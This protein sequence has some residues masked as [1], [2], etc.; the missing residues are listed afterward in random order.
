[1][2]LG[3]L[4]KKIEQVLKSNS[5]FNKLYTL[6]GSLVVKCIG[7][8][9]RLKPKTILFISYSGK[10]FN[11]SPKDIY[12]AMVNDPF[13]ADYTFIWAFKDVDK[14]E[15]GAH[16][17]KVKVDTLSYLLIAL[18][19]Q[20][21]VT[22]VNIER[23]L[24]FKKHYTKYINTWHGIP[25]KYVGNHVQ[26]RSDFNFYT[27]DVFTYSGDYEY[28]IYKEAFKLEDRNLYKYGMP[29]N[30][31]LIKNDRT[32][33]QE[34]LDAL[35]IVNKKVI[36]YA[37][38]WRDDERDLVLMDLK[39]F[40]DVLSS[41]YV[42]LIKMHGLSER[43]NISV[44]DFVMDVS[45][46]EDTSKLLLAVDVLIT[47][48]SSI[49]FDFGLLKRPIL[50]YM[51]DYDKYKKERGLYFDVEDTQLSYSTS[52]DALLAAIE[53]LNYEA[54][55]KIVAKFTQRFIEVQEVGATA[56]I[57]NTVFKET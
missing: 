50:L 17:I 6:L 5:L 38:T 56:S 19:A 55:E 25:M 27:V 30:E 11:D 26:G 32:L 47:D 1:M 4:M 8:F 45:D 29:R 15:L 12:D 24:H 20:Y 36:L 42:F 52:S 46:Y 35:G 13:F 31:I 53:S 49:M 48:Y 40:R 43:I 16:T 51:Q 9:V 39:K 44:G 3:C 7:F 23:G 34:V 14:Y 57:I 10:S 41:E 21:W 2:D 28:K 37:P 18:S 54:Q 33:R 22:N